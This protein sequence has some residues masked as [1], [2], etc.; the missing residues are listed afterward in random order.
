MPTVFRV[1]RP[2]ALAL[3]AAAQASAGEAPVTVTVGNAPEAGMLV[4]PGQV[5]AVRQA[6]L[7]AQAAGRVIEVTVRSGD[8]VRRGQPLLRI[9]SPG[10]VASAEAGSAQADAAAAQL[11][12]ARADVERARRLHDKQY[13][14]DAALERAQAQLQVVEAQATAARSQAR[15]AGE[16][17]G[18]QTLRAPYDGRITSVA[19]AAGDLASPGQPLVGVYAPGAMRVIADVPE[20]ASAQLATDRPAGL[21]FEA[22]QCANAPRVV[23]SWT[24]MPA[25]DPRSRSVGVR[26][27]L[28]EMRD[29]LPGALVRVSLPLRNGGAATLTVPRSAVVHRGE[30]DAVFVVDGN[31]RVMLRQIRLGEGSA[32]AVTVLAGLESGERVVREAQRQRAPA[33]AQGSA[34]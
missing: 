34:P 16:A 14:S 28:P 18:W 17:A 9:E 6:M 24:L 15:A 33:P 29:C 10:A 7:A 26:I 5:Q 1:L 31:G 20:G 32:D 11:A 4:A 25:I 22:G 19:V 2:T 23:Q 8:V 21:A 30:L 27:E 12:S 3:W 13:L